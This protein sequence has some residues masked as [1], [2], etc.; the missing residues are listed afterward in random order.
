M[1]ETT[2][3]GVLNDD[4]VQAYL[5]QVPCPLLKHRGG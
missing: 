1:V 4:Y 3:E 2:T 5:I